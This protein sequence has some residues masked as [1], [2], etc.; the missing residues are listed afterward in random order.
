MLVGRS[1]LTILDYFSSYAASSRS[2][3]ILLKSC[4]DLIFNV[5]LKTE[6]VQCNVNSGEFTYLFQLPTTLIAWKEVENVF[7]TRWNFPHYEGA[8]AGKH[9]VV[10]AQKNLDMEFFNYSPL[11]ALSFLL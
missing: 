9:V 8:V 1:G 11:L 4:H 5:I 7:A 10:Q 6:T 3:S 2:I